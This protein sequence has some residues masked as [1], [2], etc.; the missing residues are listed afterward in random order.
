MEGRKEGLNGEER[1]MTSCWLKNQNDVKRK[2]DTASSVALPCGVTGCVYDAYLPTDFSPSKIQKQNK[3]S[4]G[5]LGVTA[6]CAVSL[7]REQ[8]TE[9]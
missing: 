3:I 4:W 5:R 9:L 8:G 1:A 6:A 7:C 2:D